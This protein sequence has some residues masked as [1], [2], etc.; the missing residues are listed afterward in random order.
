[1]TQQRP[2]GTVVQEIWEVVLVYG[3][4]QEPS[5]GDQHSPRPVVEDLRLVGGEPPLLL[6]LIFGNPVIP[7]IGNEGIYIEDILKVIFFGD[8]ELQ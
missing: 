4:L 8:I 3:E 5:G 1:M 2:S 7:F 6:I